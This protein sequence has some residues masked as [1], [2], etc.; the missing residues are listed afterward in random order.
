MNKKANYDIYANWKNPLV[1]MAYTTIFQ[2]LNSIVTEMK[3]MPYFKY[4]YFQNCILTP[5]TLM[6]GI[7]WSQ[8]QQI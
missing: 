3:H 5:L 4:N 6:F 1:S 8:I 7:V 2:G